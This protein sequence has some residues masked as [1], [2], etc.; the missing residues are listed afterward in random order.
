[1]PSELTPPAC[2]PIPCHPVLSPRASPNPLPFL[3]SP[4]LFFSSSLSP[5]LYPFP[6]FSACPSSVH[7]RFDPANLLVGQR[8]VVREIEAR[9][10]RIDERSLLLNVWTE[11]VAQSLVH[12]MRRRMVAHRSSTR[13]LVDGSGDRVA[14]F[15]LASLDFP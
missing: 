10:L 5:S 7:E 11:H 12:Q 2:T 6:H 15:Q 9:T 13:V 4:C 14:D 1:M 3:P 8:C